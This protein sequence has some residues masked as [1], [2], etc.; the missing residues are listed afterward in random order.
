[1]DDAVIAANETEELAVSTQHAENHIDTRCV[2]A[3]LAS[4]KNI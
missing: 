4:L 1:M 2:Y 3:K